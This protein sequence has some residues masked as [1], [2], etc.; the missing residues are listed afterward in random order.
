PYESRRVIGL[1]SYFLLLRVARGAKGGARTGHVSFHPSNQAFGVSSGKMNRLPSFGKV[2][3]SQRRQGAI[4]RDKVAFAQSEVKARADYSS[5]RCRIVRRRLLQNS[6]QQSSVGSLIE[7]DQTR[8]QPWTN[9][10]LFRSNEAIISLSGLF[11]LAHKN[12]SHCECPKI[13][14]VSRIQLTCMLQVAHGIMPTAM[15]AINQPIQLKNSCV[16]GQSA[17]GNGELVIGAVVIAVA[18]VK[19]QSQGKV[20]LARIGFQSKSRIARDGLVKQFHGLGKGRLFTL[21]TMWPGVYQRRS[22]GVQIVSNEVLSRSRF[23][24]HLFSS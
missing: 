22:V 12:V 6:M 20:C 7:V 5:S 2:I 16:V 9:L 1:R 4:G 8:R 19:V 24:G 14:G 18:P 11:I 3:L 15:P 13:R 10:V 17:A 23:D 21:G